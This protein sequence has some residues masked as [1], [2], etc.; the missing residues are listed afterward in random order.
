MGKR[1]VV[2]ISQN[3]L[4]VRSLHRAVMMRAR[5][6]PMLSFV[7]GGT[8]LSAHIRRGFPP[9]YIRP[10]PFAEGRTSVVGTLPDQKGSD[11]HSDPKSKDRKKNES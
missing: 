1:G 7:T 4:L 11:A 8:R 9:A 5:P 10:S 3:S 2:E 6:K